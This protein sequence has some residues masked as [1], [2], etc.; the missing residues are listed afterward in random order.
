MSRPAVLL[1]LAVVLALL[2]TGCTQSGVV[3]RTPAGAEIVQIPLRFSN[4]FLVKTKRPILVDTGTI[5]DMEDLSRALADSG[6]STTSIR[7]IILTHAHADHA[8]LA[9]EIQ[10]LSLARVFIG[11]GDVPLAQNGHND[12]LKPTGFGAAV[13]KPFIPDIY[14]EF[15]PDLVVR[16]PVDLSPYGI[17]G[18]LVQMPGHTAGSL[19]IVMRNHAAFVGDMMRGDM[20]S[21]GH[22]REHYFHADPAQNRKNI[23]TLLEM[24]VETFYLGHGGPVSRADVIKAFDIH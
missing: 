22:P 14:P 12:V 16:D 10:K 4:V 3:G 6:V 18:T 1:V 24:G 17:D 5:G 9:A 2:L 7:L 23:A 13:L 11:E 21:P 8:G 15:S 20:L 19:V